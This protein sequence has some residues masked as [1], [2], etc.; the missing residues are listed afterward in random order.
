VSDDT[1]LGSFNIPE[2]IY[3]SAKTAIPEPAALTLLGVALTGL[4]FAHRRRS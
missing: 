2:I 1:A 4:G 3:G